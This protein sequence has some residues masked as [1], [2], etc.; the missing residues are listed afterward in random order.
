MESYYSSKGKIFHL[1]DARTIIIPDQ[2]PLSVYP[3]TLCLCVLLR[4][5]L[6]IPK[7]DT[8]QTYIYLF[9]LTD[10]GILV[11]KRKLKKFKFRKL[12]AFC[13]SH[14]YNYYSAE[15]KF[16]DF[17][18]LK[19]IKLKEQPFKQKYKLVAFKI[20]QDE[21]FHKKETF[22]LLQKHLNDFKVLQNV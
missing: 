18:T 2:Q 16:Y 7:K 13:E 15:S 17:S 19:I 4:Q 12:L 9:F 6:E 5:F 1:S 11:Y 21:Y 10:E 8:D 20:G 14:R 3:R 22:L